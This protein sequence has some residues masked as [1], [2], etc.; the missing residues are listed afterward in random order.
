MVFTVNAESSFIYSCL[1]FNSTIRLYRASK[2]SQFSLKVDICEVFENI[3]AG[4]QAA[5][6]IIQQRAR[7][8]LKAFLFGQ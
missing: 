6:L 1:G 3:T 5:K 4:R 7:Q 8:S 2:I